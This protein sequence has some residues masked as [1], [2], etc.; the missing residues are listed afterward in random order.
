MDKALRKKI[1]ASVKRT[2]AKKKARIDR[3]LALLEKFERAGFVGA[4]P[5]GDR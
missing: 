2:L 4:E 3:A 1:A 5:G